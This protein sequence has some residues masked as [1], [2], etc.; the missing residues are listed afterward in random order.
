L[1]WELLKTFV[2]EA[3]YMRWFRDV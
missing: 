1:L 3:T 2:E